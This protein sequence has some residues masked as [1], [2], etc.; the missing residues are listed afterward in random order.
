MLVMADSRSALRD[1]IKQK[2]PFQAGGR[3]S[4]RGHSAHG[5]RA[6]APLQPDRDQARDH[7]SAVQR[8]ANPARRRRRG[9]ADARHP[10]PDDSRSARDHAAARQAGARRPRSAGAPGRRPPPGDVLHHGERSEAPR[11]PRCRSG[12]RRPRRGVHAGP[13]GAASV[14]RAAG[15]RAVRA[16]AAVSPRR[17]RRRTGRNHFSAANLR[18][19]RR[20]YRGD[21]PR[22]RHC[23]A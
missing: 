16:R 21:G 2:R 4:G 20:A 18:A 14:D 22:S 9:H 15:R 1:E 6:R 13:R 10:R 3:R 19:N 8:A 11:R 12:R 5:R 7:D 23:L 17:R